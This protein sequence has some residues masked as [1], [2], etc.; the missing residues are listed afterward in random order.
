MRQ[1][2]LTLYSFDDLTEK[3]QKVIVD[4]ERWNIME[5]CM[6]SYSIDYRNSLEQFE[7]LFEINCHDWEVGYCSY[8]YRFRINK[9]EAFEWQHDGWQSIPLESLSGKLLVRYLQQNILPGILKGKYY[10]KLKGVYPNAIH[11]KRYS[12]IFFESDCPLTGCCYDHDLINPV[13]EYLAKPT[14]NITYQEL[15]RNCLVQFFRT[16]HEEYKYWA[17]DEDAIREQLHNNQYEDMLFHAN[18]IEYNGPLGNVA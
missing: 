15:V 1:I 12:K 9:E 18:G 7:K 17:N 4:R 2:Q 10:G 11:Y 6:D 5:S 16:W 14:P 3:V 8:H 13:L